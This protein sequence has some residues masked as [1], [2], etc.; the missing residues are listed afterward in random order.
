MSGGIIH[1]VVADLV[2]DEQVWLG[3][4]LHPLSN[5]IVVLRLLQRLNQ[6]M[7][8]REIDGLPLFNRLQCEG[9]GQVSLPH[10][11]RAE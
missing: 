2:D 8:R 5:G 4:R 11:G 1:P 3:Q 7:P 6:I 9:N 10:A